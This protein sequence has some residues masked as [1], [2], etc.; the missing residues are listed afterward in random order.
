MRTWKEI[1]REE[2]DRMTEYKT[3]YEWDNNKMADVVNLSRAF[4]NPHTPTCLTCHSSFR[5]TINNLRSWYL[6]YKDQIEQMFAEQDAKT[7]KKNVKSK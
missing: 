4:V 7:T 3:R 6:Q 2:F 5:E 1:T